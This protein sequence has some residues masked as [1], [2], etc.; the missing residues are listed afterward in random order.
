[1]LERLINKSYRTNSNRKDKTYSCI[2]FKLSCDRSMKKVYEFLNTN[3]YQSAE[4]NSE[5]NEI[6]CES[7]LFEYTLTFLNDGGNSI[8]TVNVYNPSHPFKTK[9]MLKILLMGI[10]SNLKDYII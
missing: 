9:K 10:R 3:D 1:M 8:M 7:Q 5:Y 2:I 6:Y 4:I